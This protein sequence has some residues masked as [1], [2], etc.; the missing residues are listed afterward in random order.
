MQEKAQSLARGKIG[1]DPWMRAVEGKGR[2]FTLGD[3]T[4]TQGSVSSVEFFFSAAENLRISPLS[5]IIFLHGAYLL[6]VK[7]LHKKASIWH[8]C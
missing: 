3:C 4:C 1:V 8:I 5:L 2:I 6:L 7:W